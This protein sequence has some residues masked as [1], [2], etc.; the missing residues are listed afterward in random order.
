MADGFDVLV[1]D[2]IYQVDLDPEDFRSMIYGNENSQVIEWYR[3]IIDPDYDGTRNQADA[4]KF[5][6]LRERQPQAAN[7]RVAI[8]DARVMKRYLPQGEFIAGDLTVM[9]MPDEMDIGDHDWIIPL[10][11]VE[12]SPLSRTNAKLLTSKEPM[13]R[14]KTEIAMAG[15]ISSSG[16]AVTGIGT[17]FTLLRQGDILKA[18]V[19]SAIVESVEDEVSLTLADAPGVAW[20]GNS[21]VRCVEK[22]RL[23]PV[24][25]IEEIRDNTSVYTLGVDYV[26]ADDRRSVQ[27]MSGHTPAMGAR[28]SVVYKY[29]PKYEVIGDLGLVNHAVQGVPLPTT[30]T[31][32][33]VPPDTYAE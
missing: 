7:Y 26:L 8:A 22:L 29:V 2:N 9:F 4:D 5:K 30:Y 19:R 28:C 12:A 32:R 11:R 18:A 27:W 23:Y 24:A 1:R 10:G 3:A 16:T 17:D 15:T 31:M 33:L 13:Q 25:A 6:W 20:S 21:F 14:G